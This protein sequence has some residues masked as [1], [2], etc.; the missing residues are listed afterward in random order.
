MISF[1]HPIKSVSWNSQFFLSQWIKNLPLVYTVWIFILFTSNIRFYLTPSEILDLRVG[2]WLLFF[3]NWLQMKS[4]H[5]WNN[6]YI[7]HNRNFELCLL[8]YLASGVLFVPDWT[9]DSGSSMRK[10]EPAWSSL[11]IAIL[12]SSVC[13]SSLNGVSVYTIDAREAILVKYTQNVLKTF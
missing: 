4:S 7:L 12:Y 10:D 11:R 5:A 6:T 9:E 2:V 1:D 13:S 3:V 8:L